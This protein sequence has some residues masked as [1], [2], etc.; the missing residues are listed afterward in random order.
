MRK[1]AAKTVTKQK[2]QQFQ[3][4]LEEKSRILERSHFGEKGRDFVK[5]QSELEQKVVDAQARFRLWEN[6]SPRKI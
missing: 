6:P 5:Q 2:Q 4:I 1:V 3:K